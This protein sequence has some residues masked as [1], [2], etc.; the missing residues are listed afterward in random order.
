MPFEQG[1]GRAMEDARIERAQRHV[2]G[3]ALPGGGTVGRVR[4]VSSADDPSSLFWVR[5][6]SFRPNRQPPPAR[7]CP[8]FSAGYLTNTGIKFM[9]LV[10]DVYLDPEDGSRIRG[11]RPLCDDPLFPSSR[12]GGIVNREADLKKIF[13]SCCRAPL[14]DE[15]NDDDFGM[16]PENDS[17]K[18]LFLAL[19]LISL[20][21]PLSRC[22]RL[23]ARASRPGCTTC[24]CGTP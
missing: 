14:V 18:P 17:M 5:I 10:E 24:T 15:N 9:V 4:C 13:V 12:D 19:S 7:C 11:D 23:R 16:L 1:G 2:D 20:S 3:I 22:V 6:I 8:R 21:P